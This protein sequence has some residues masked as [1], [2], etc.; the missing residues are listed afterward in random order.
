MYFHIMEDNGEEVTWDIELVA[1]PLILQGLITV[2]Y[3]GRDNNIEAF[4]HLFD[5]WGCSTIRV[6]KFI[7]IYWL[8][9]IFKPKCCLD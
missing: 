2:V 6:D 8:E 9:Y 3:A 1:I 5:E 4:S 7:L